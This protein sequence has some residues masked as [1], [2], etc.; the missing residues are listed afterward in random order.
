MPGGVAAALGFR[1][2]D[3]LEKPSGMWLM[4]QVQAG[5]TYT[6][7]TACVAGLSV[8]E[9]RELC[10]RQCGNVW[11]LYQGSHK[12]HTSQR[13]LTPASTQRQAHNGPGVRKQ[14]SFFH[15]ELGQGACP[16]WI[17][18]HIVGV[19]MSSMHSLLAALENLPAT[20]SRRQG[21]GSRL[22]IAYN[23]TGKT[24]LCYTSS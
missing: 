2:P 14:D 19:Q 20:W 17:N 21:Q 15:H 6:K 13:G 8:L 4:G 16:G 22:P 9:H 24:G 1:E 3:S 10:Q 7:E 23:S 18:R 12:S 5:A 11:D